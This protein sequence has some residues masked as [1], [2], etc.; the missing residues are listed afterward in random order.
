MTDLELVTELI[1]KARAAQQE[2]E[3]YSQEQVDKAVR[4]VGKVIYD[5]GDELAKMAVEETRMGDYA[6]KIVKNTA[7]AK[8]VWYRMK[9][10]KSRGI[11]ERDELN[12]IIARVGAKDG[13]VIFFGA[14]K[15]KIV[16]D[17]LGALRLKIGRSKFGEEH[18][19]F[20]HG[21]KPLWVVNFPMFEYSEEEDRWV[22]CHHPFT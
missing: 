8:A 20:T 16:W 22:A 6:S 13:D 1:A 15:A 21:W 14:D 12:G 2:F 9:G 19:L 11:I 17:S 18:G 3:T 10:V 7:K 5:H 4:A